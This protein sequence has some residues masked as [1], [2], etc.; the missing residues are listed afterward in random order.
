MRAVNKQTTLADCRI[1]VLRDV[2][3]VITAGREIAELSRHLHA[4]RATQ[5]AHG[6]GLRSD[7]QQP[8]P[9]RRLGRGAFSAVVQIA[10]WRESN[11]SDGLRS[12]GWSVRYR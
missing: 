10:W 8:C 12:L 11:L 6:R 4:P 7:R 1:N 5:I 9:E 2:P 3:A